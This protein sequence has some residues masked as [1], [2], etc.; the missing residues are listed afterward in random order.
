ME[1]NGRGRGTL[2]EG[3]A[4]GE[5]PSTLRRSS[6]LNPG[7]GRRK[8]RTASGDDQ[9]HRARQQ[10]SNGAKRAATMMSEKGVPIFVPLAPRVAGSLPAGVSIFNSAASGSMAFAA[11]GSVPASAPPSH[12]IRGGS[13]AAAEAAS[14]ALPSGSAATAIPV[15]DG[16]VSTEFGVEGVGE[17]GQ[18][19]YR[20]S[21]PPPAR[22]NTVASA[23][24]A[25]SVPLHMTGDPIA[26][27][28][29][30]L[31]NDY[32]LECAKDKKKDHRRFSLR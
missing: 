5:E 26:P 28:E 22:S 9:I 23:L 8:P 13:R 30:A 11:P 1:E 32:A 21:M 24:V 17:F 3:D 10:P 31:V 7:P 2:G 15:T 4:G 29:A 27:A 19:V 16:G 18:K 12:P 6:S 14:C 20:R 25:S